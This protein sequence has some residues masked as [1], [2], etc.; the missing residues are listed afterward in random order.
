VSEKP[1]VL[2]VYLSKG[3]VAKSTLA[4]LIA[5]YLAALGNTVVLLDL[6]RQGSQSEIFDLIGPDGRTDEVLPHRLRKR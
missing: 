6:D 2:T 5:E 1:T 3:G 4:A